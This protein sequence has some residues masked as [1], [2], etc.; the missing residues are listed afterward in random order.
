MNYLAP[1]T[2]TS[3]ELVFT[4]DLGPDRVD[5]VRSEI[6]AHIDTDRPQLRIR[7]SNVGSLHLG[8]ANVLVAA[9]REARSHCGDIELI[10]DR[11]SEAQRVLGLVGIVGTITP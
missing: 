5:P 9:Q 11:D 10:V 6:A 1:N 3:H 7:L 4:G 8:V 2:P